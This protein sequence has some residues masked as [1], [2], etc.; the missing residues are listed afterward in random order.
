[1]LALLRTRIH[2]QSDRLPR[3]PFICCQIIAFGIVMS[4]S[5]CRP[6]ISQASRVAWQHHSPPVQRL[7]LDEFIVTPLAVDGDG[8]LWF[9]HQNLSGEGGVGHLVSGAVGDQM[10][11]MHPVR[12]NDQGPES[13]FVLALVPDGQGGIWVGTVHGGLS[14]YDGQTHSWTRI[15]APIRD[16]FAIVPDGAGLWLATFDSG[17]VH[18]DTGLQQWTAYTVATTAGGIQDDQVIKLIPDGAGGLW[19][20]TYGGGVSHYDPESDSWRALTGASTEGGPGSEDVRALVAGESGDLWV[21]TFGGGISHYD[22][23]RDAWELYTVETTGRGLASNYVL[24]LLPDGD[25]R[26]WAGLSNLRGQGGL[27][28]F[29]GK[30]W[31]SYTVASTGG[32]LL[33]DDV[34][35]IAAD[36][37]GGL[38]VGT[39]G[40]GLSH[41]SADRQTWTV[42]TADS[43][44]G[45]LAGDSVMALEP[46]LEGGMWVGTASGLSHLRWRAP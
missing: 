37:T 23:R 21:G 34:R 8:D 26:L 2:S 15:A 29:D 44:G 43:T 9:G 31:Q 1:M 25:T 5:A 38:W 7:T 14:H 27:A 35:A 20:G 11:E 12:P 24:T 45:G 40:G 33:S 36:G 28:Y 6:A 41:L 16:V 46:D 10:W 4:L 13:S 3:I 19:A 30:A 42:Y 17:V 39:R 32:G 18:Y 22:P